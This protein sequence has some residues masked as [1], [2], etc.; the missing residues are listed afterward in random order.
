MAESYND[1]ELTRLVL[2][3]QEGRL[4]ATLRRVQREREAAR[5]TYCRLCAAVERLTVERDKARRVAKVLA[6][7]AAENLTP[8]ERQAVETAEAYPEVK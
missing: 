8:M 7:A 2:L 1:E 5:D 6:E 4:M 3:D